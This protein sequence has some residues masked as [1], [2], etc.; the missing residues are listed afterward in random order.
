MTEHPSDQVDIGQLK[1]KALIQLISFPVTVGICFFWPAGTFQY[2][3]AWV[4]IGVFS[5]M[6][7]GMTM[8]LL[9]NDPQL[10]ERRLDRGESRKDQ[11]LV[12]LLSTLILL[13]IFLLPGFDQ[14]YGWSTVPLGLVLFGDFIVMGSYYLFFRVLR[15][16]SYASRV[17]KVEQGIQHVI[18][19]G[20]YA[21]VRHPMYFTIILMFGAIPLA[22]GSYWG[23]LPV[24]P[25]IVLLAFRVWDE[26]KLLVEELEGYAEYKKKTRYRIFPGIW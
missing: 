25:L 9:K 4:F 1:K 18:T 10:L 2:W 22:T 26:E 11:K 5:A 12:I 21:I 20:P 16:N 6:M 3:E 13:P 19:T 7:F 8:Y 24:F 23:V 17:V 14:R 15:E